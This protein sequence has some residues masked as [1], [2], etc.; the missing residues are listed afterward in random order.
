M[1]SCPVDNSI[2]A[3]PSLAKGHF[4]IRCRVCGFASAA[5]NDFDE[6]D[7]YISTELRFG[8]NALDGAVDEAEVLGYSVFMTDV[9]GHKMGAAVASVQASNMPPSTTGTCCQPDVYKVT[10]TAQL[11]FNTSRMA[12]MVVPN[13]TAGL[14]PVGAFTSL[15]VDRRPPVQAAAKQGIVGKVSCATTVLVSRWLMWMCMA[16]GVAKETHLV[17]LLPWV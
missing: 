15:V 1:F 13:T 16:V 3:E 9:C 12:L 5:P 2:H 14:L 8:P 6:R 10:F 7:G 4:S 17:G 11:P